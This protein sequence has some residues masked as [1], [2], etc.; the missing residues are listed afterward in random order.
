MTMLTES[1]LKADA[2]IS[3]TMIDAGDYYIGIVE[4]GQTLRLLDLEGNQA[5]DTRCARV[6]V[7]TLWRC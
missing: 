2:A 5:A 6:Y 1:T 3:R 7:G 4:A